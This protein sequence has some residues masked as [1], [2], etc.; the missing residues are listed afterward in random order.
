MRWAASWAL[1]WLGDLMFRIGDA[2]DIFDDHGVGWL[3]WQA[4]QRPMA[5]ASRIQGDG[6]GPWRR[7]LR[8]RQVGA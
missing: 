6:P 3:L 4:Y 8:R 1:Y 5:W 2:L 7:S